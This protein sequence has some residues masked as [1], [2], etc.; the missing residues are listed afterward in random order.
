MKRAKR[1][2][3]AQIQFTKIDMTFIVIIFTR[4]Q[5]DQHMHSDTPKKKTNC[6]RDGALI[7]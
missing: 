6:D 1:K 5:T 3:N 4:L 7:V 2:S